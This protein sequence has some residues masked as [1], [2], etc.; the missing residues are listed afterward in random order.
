MLAPLPLTEDAELDMPTEAL[1]PEETACDC[2]KAALD[3]AKVMME[4]MI[5]MDFM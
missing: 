3:K 2:A 5:A 1:V 4:A